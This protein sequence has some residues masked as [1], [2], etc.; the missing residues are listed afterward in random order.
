MRHTQGLVVDIYPHNTFIETQK[1]Q[2][3]REYSPNLSNNI[4]INNYDTAS[5]MM[6]NKSMIPLESENQNI[7]F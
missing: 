6:V 5:I 2:R 4:P 3:V 7:K 1:N